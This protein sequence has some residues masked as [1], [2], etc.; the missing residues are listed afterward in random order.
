MKSKKD[1]IICIYKF[2]NFIYQFSKTYLNK[3]SEKIN[4]NNCN[5][6][7]M[8][9][10][11]HYYLDGENFYHFPI[12]MDFDGS[13]WNEGN[14]YILNISQNIHFHYTP[15]KILRKASQLIDY[16]IWCEK[17]SIDMFDFSAI[18]P[19]NRPTYRY[20]KYLSETGISPGNLNQRTSLIYNFTKFYCKK[21]KINESKIDKLSKVIIRCESKT[22][23]TLLKEVNKRELTRKVTRKLIPSIGKVIDDGEALRPLVGDE[24]ESLINTLEKDCFNHDEKLIFQ[25]A[26]ETGARKQS[27][28]TIRIKHL[29]FF[30]ND[31]LSSNGYF[32]LPIGPGTGIDTKRDKNISLYIPQQL[33]NKLKMYISSDFFKKRK[34]KFLYKFGDEFKDH[35]D[36][37]IFLTNNGNCRYMAKNDPRFFKTKSPQKGC[38][39]NTIIKKIYLNLEGSF[40]KDYTFHWNRA[41]F[42]LNYFIFLNELVNKKIIT[43]QDQI[44]FIQDKLGH[45]DPSTTE[46]YLKLFSNTEMLVEMQSNWESKFFSKSTFK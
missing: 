6:Y 4:L 26:L 36:I 44:A 3:H 2:P 8:T 21:Y 7:H 25:T 22:G 42:A 13:A 14:K 34:E 1:R 30:T 15:N 11:Q 31:N 37:Y 12:L 39:I 45:S 24:Q 43:Y 10:N 5:S 32:K 27:I 23:Q 46:D 9:S 41:T 38:S 20:F 17:N 19:R 29:K 40:P 28:L 18:R 35:N 33:A 16:K